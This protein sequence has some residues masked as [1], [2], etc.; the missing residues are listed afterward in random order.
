MIWQVDNVDTGNPHE[1]G[2]GTWNIC[3]G[4]LSKCHMPQTSVHPELDGID[5]FGHFLSGMKLIIRTSCWFTGQGKK[6]D[7]VWQFGNCGPVT[8]YI[9]S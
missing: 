7:C 3:Y 6:G 1:M 4:I 8:T 9:Y 2:T 5:C